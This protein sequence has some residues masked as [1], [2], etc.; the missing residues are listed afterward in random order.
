MRFETYFPKVSTVDA[1][2]ERQ[3]RRKLYALYLLSRGM[4][5]RLEI[6]HLISHVEGVG[7][8]SG[9]LRRIYDSMVEEKPNSREV[10]E[11]KVRYVA[12]HARAY[13]GWTAVMPDPGLGFR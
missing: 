7:S 3:V 5:I 12:R 2:W 4:D 8:R 13:R 1:D 11:M 10:L 9:A 6:D